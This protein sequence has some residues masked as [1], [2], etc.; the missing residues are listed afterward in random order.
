METKTNTS[1]E[2]ERITRIYSWPHLYQEYEKFLK[3]EK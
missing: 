2:D 3:G 1:F